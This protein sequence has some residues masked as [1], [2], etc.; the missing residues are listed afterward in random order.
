MQPIELPAML[1]GALAAPAGDGPAVLAPVTAGRQGLPASSIGLAAQLA[2]SAPAALQ[3]VPLV[4][5]RGA[6]HASWAAALAAKHGRRVVTLA[7]ALPTDRAHVRDV[8]AL[9][10]LHD[11]DRSC[12]RRNVRR[13][14]S[15][16]SPPRLAGPCAAT[17]RPARC[18]ALRSSAYMTRHSTFRA[19]LPPG[20][21]LEGGAQRAP[22]L[23]V[24]C[25]LRGASVSKKCRWRVVRTLRMQPG[26]PML[27]SFACAA[28]RRRHGPR[29]RVGRV[30]L[31][32]LCCRR[33]GRA[34]STYRGP[35]LAHA[36]APRMG[37]GAAWNESGLAVLFAVRPAP[38]RR[39]RPRRWRM[40]WRCRLPHRPLAGGQQ[41]HR[42]NREEP[43]EIF[44]V[45]EARQ[46]PAVRRRMLCRQAHRGQGRTRPLCRISRSVTCR[47]AWSA[48]RA[49]P[50]SPPIGAG[51]RR[52]VHPPAA[53]G[54][55]RCPARSSASASGGRCS[56]RVSM[57]RR[58][59]FSLPRRGVRAC[60]RASRSAAFSA[61]A[62]RRCE[63]RAVSP[64]RPTRSS[65][66]GTARLT[67]SPRRARAIPRDTDLVR[68]A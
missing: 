43:R 4:G 41:I 22:R 46:R 9:C 37:H 39:W 66:S 61:C 28:P 67:R 36:R 68:D 17:S 58:S 31:D 16:G 25:Q 51:S 55:V 20:A 42:R 44:D 64:C 49:S 32:E 11:V 21:Q 15:P 33:G 62:R 10:W 38:A 56:R 59:I 53:C 5:R 65:P 30:S 34:R 35:A 6:D 24:R 7:A 27:T 47:N 60:R 14:A 26:L 8:L 50:F 45:A 29:W 13:A 18:S 2:T 3:L 23:A 52:G 1:V 12:R 48:S 19:R 63:R 54:G 57:S 40:R